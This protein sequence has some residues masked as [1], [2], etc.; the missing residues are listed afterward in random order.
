MNSEI[1]LIL[2]SASPQRRELLG[3]LGV[4]FEIH[5]PQVDESALPGETPAQL[6]ARLAALKSAA[7]QQLYPEAAVL[8][9]DTVISCDGRVLG[10]AAD[11][12]GAFDMLMTLSGRTHEVLTAVCLRLGELKKAQV[13][14][15]EVTFAELTPQLVWWYVNGGEYE[16]K[17]GSYAVQGQASALIRSVNG[18]VSSVVGLPL[19]EVR[20]MLS[21]LD[22]FQ[23]RPC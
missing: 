9:A 19:C 15:S 10:K 8:A 4:N 3:K 23:V 14:R 13:V 2:A 22:L 12:Q 5:P 21:E 18:S 20:T 6:V 16:G 1:K 17:S 7:V 11:R